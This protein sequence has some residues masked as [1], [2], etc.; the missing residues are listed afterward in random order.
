MLN[1]YL[2]NSCLHELCSGV[3][4]VI[5]SVLLMFTFTFVKEYP[6]SEAQVNIGVMRHGMSYTYLLVCF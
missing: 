4:L 2:L 5:M 6:G 3:L 1:V